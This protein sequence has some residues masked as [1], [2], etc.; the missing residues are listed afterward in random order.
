MFCPVASVK[1]IDRMTARNTLVLMTGKG[2]TR[3]MRSRTRSHE[4]AVFCRR[5]EIRRDGLAEFRPGSAEDSP[6]RP[7][8]KGRSGLDVDTPDES[9]GTGGAGAISESVLGGATMPRHVESSA[10]IDVSPEDVFAFVD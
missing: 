7:R 10:F 1:T 3:A 2:K 9:G 4:S 8:P 5:V 6:A